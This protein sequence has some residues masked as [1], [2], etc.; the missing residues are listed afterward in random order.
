M[1]ELPRAEYGVLQPLLA[2]LTIH[3]HRALPYA[4][5]E[6]NQDGRVFVD[7]SACPRL[8]LACPDSGFHFA[9]GE[10]DMDAVRVVLPELPLGPREDAVLF[11]TSPAWR[12][13]LA[14]LFPRHLERRGFVLDQRDRTCRDALPE[15]PPG[16]E[17]RSL[18]LPLTLR[19]G[20]GLDPWVVEIYG[21]PEGFLQ[22]SF[23]FGVLDLRHDG[24]LVAFTAACAV[25]AGE[26]EVEV[27]T[28]PEYR[29]Q[30]LA[31][32]ATRRFLAECAT[33]GFQP[34]WNCVADNIASVRLAERLGFVEVERLTGFPLAS[35]G[36]AG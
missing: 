17:L 14:P 20:Q 28:A 21:G 25:G 22:N 35:T 30:G 31:H 19:W 32:C 27:G 8:A 4:L 15:L 5:L 9:L 24:R 13:C 7:D 6:G 29:Q 10:P 12:E 33:R 16:F 1:R 11:A 18:D 36:T 3:T 26:A 2:S 34:T 23:G